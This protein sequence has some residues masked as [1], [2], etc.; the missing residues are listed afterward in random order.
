MKEETREKL[1]IFLADYNLEMMNSM[2]QDGDKQFVLMGLISLI[3]DDI[4]REL[5][6]DAEQTI[7]S[8]KSKG[9]SN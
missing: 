2:S 6:E 7:M 1:V 5:Y 3:E 4:L 9:D 8:R